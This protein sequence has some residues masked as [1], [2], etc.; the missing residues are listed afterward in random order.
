MA[1]V[2]HTKSESFFN[3]GVAYL[4]RID[5]I[6]YLCWMNSQSYNVAGW[7]SQLRALFRELSV[8][9][10]EP[11]QQIIMD[12]FKKINSK[13]NS[14]INASNLNELLSS[15]DKLEIKLRGIAQKKGMLLP[16]KEDQSR[17]I[18]QR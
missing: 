11:E 3:M 17:A 14:G 12:D 4:K 6:L 1:A 9:V 13:V 10:S 8:K 15:L 5:K 7:L 18:T 2:D 16:G